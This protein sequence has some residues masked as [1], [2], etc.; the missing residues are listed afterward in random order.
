MQQEW[1]KVYLD[2]VGQVVHPSGINSYSRNLTTALSFAFKDQALDKTPVLFL[3]L[4]ANYYGRGSVM[5]NGEAYSSYPEEGE[6][7]LMEGVGVRILGFDSEVVFLN[8]HQS[9]QNYFD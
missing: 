2:N 1:I 7:L 9:F 6:M 5:M 3:L 4:N 8:K